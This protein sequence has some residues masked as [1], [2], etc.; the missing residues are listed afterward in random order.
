M[1]ESVTFLRLRDEIELESLKLETCRRL[2]RYTNNCTSTP[3]IETDEKC[4]ALLVGHFW[5]IT[6]RVLAR[7]KIWRFNTIARLYP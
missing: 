2:A 5:E 1:D 4:H 6:T 7:A 3:V